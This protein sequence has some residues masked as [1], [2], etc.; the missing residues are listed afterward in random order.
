MSRPATAPPTEVELQIL[1]VLWETGPATVREIHNHMAVY[2]ETNYATTVKMLIVMLEKGLVSRDDS[3]RPQIY[4]SAVTQTKTQQKMLNELVR[5]VYDGSTESLI[6]HALSS[7]KTSQEDIDE[8]RNLL[9]EM[10][11]ERK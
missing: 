1:R 5:K 3:V 6:M 4:Q 10:D 7:K 11:E 8:I 9:N 2:K